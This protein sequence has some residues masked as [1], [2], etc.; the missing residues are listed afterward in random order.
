[1]KVYI[2]LD[3]ILADFT[4]G[5]IKVCEL[6]MTYADWDVWEGYSKHVH[7]AV[8]W[9]RI[10]A[11]GPEFWAE[12]ELTPEAHVIVGKALEL[13][14]QAHILTSGGCPG[15]ATGKTL[16]IEEH[17]PE[18]RNRTILSDQK[19]RFAAPDTLLVDDYEKNIVDFE[20]A[21]G[22]VLMLKRPWNS[23]SPLGVVLAAMD[24]LKLER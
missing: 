12:L 17:F 16:W 11:T 1:M 9:G 24:L 23:G 18:F 3:G 21:G 10:K 5:A 7:K 20:D 4:T 15:A 14:P 13:D 2:D 6:P 19:Q 22:R 8:F